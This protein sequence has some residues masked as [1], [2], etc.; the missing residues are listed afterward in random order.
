VGRETKN[1][2][3]PPLRRET[4]FFS[5]L[6]SPGRAQLP[7]RRL[8]ARVWSDV[9]WALPIIRNQRSII[10]NR[11]DLYSTQPEKHRSDCWT[12]LR[13]TT[14]V[15]FGI[16]KRRLRRVRGR[17]PALITVTSQGE[18][19]SVAIPRGENRASYRP[20]RAASRPKF[21]R[22]ETSL[23]E[24]IIARRNFRNQFPREN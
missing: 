11:A 15:E 21:N 7:P 9:R 16:L 17:T 3:V 18:H 5:P 22:D 20:S 14:T 19:R 13:K 10:A 12:P 2:S 24:S 23:A 8:F 4:P 6:L 1:W